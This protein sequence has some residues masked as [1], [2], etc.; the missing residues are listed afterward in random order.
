MNFKYIDIGINL[1]GKQFEKDRDSVVTDSL[2]KS[3]GLVITGTDVK[4][5]KNAL[6]YVK[7]NNL[8]GLWSTCG[9]HPH[10]ASMWTENYK[11]EFLGVLKDKKVVAIG[12]IGLDYDRMYSPREK[13]LECFNDILQIAED[14][15]LKRPLFL[16]ER[17]ADG[18]FVRLLKQHKSVCNRSIVHCFTGDRATALRY[19]NLGCYIGITGWV[20]D[21][22]RNKELVDALKVIPLERLMVE[23]DAPYLTPLNKGLDRRNVPENIKYV[24]EEIAK[25]KGLDVEEVRKK[26]LENTLKV[27]HIV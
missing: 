5:S 9:T 2:N 14:D 15:A 4:S 24:V 26:T 20:C 18:D 11:S 21:T 25:I 3:I 1:M 7:R 23:T 10:N 17:S 6:E 12:E 22:R 19:L 16:H 13:Q 27:F 8:E